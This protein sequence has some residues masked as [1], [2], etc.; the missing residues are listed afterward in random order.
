MGVY[1]KKGT[2]TKHDKMGIHFF[3]VVDP[4]GV[5]PLTSRVRFTKSIV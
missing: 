5:E 4:R 1:E 2:P 3:V